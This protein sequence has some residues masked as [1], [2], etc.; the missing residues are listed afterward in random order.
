MSNQD[1]VDYISS[2][3]EPTYQVITN[4]EPNSYKVCNNISAE[5]PDKLAIYII[6]TIVINK[7]YSI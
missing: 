1:T 5:I 3:I 4:Y 6:K 2:Y 7:N